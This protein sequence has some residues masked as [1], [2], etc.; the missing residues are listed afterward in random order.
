MCGPGSRTRLAQANPSQSVGVCTERMGDCPPAP[1]LQEARTAEDPDRGGASDQMLLTAVPWGVGSMP[2]EGVSGGGPFWR[3]PSRRPLIRL[4]EH[5]H[6][7]SSGVASRDTSRRAG[8]PQGGDV[9][10]VTQPAQTGSR[11]GPL[12]LGFLDPVTQSPARANPASGLSRILAPPPR[13]A[14]GSPLSPPRQR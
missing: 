10:E 11:D 2:G 5:A 13:N 14:T 1:S 12:S 6:V 3:F 9:A 8:R 7:S 4:Q